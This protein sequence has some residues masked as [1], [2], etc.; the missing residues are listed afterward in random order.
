[1]PTGPLLAT[2][3]V[4]T[5]ATMALYSLPT[6][7][8]EVARD[9]RVNGTLAGGFVAIAYGVGIVSALLSPGLIRRH[10]GVRA[11]QVVL[12]AAAAMLVAAAFSS[13]IATLA[14][15][16]V[17]L[18][19][20]Y[21]AAAPA[22]THLLVPH[23]PR[24]IFNTVMSI[25]Q[26]G[27]PRGGVAAALTLPPLVPVFGWRGSLLL[28]LIP[29]L[30][31]ILLMELP[32]RHWDAD[33][34]PTVRP[35]GRTLL[36]P[37]LLLTDRRIRRLSV[38]CFIFSGLQ[39][40]FV[41]FTTVHLTT[42]TGLDLVRAGQMLAAYQIAGSVSR[43]IWGWVADRYLTPIQTLGFLGA[44]MAV[45]AAMT[46][47]YGR[48]WTPLEILSVSLV[49]GCTAGGYTGVAYAEYAS[50]GGARRTEATGLGTA[51]MFSGGLLIPPLFGASVVGWGGFDGAY[52]VM[53]I[54]A[55][56]SGVLMAWPATRNWGH[57]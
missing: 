29:V 20:G 12:L 14:C 22:S 57:L 35:F 26:I 50:L 39:L 11:T 17:V 4:Q 51:L 7:A 54:L 31:L 46:A 3:A 47:Q 36:Q 56:A 15:A 19:C 24:P 34:D 49:A 10:G 53:A 16:A 28:E 6:L 1:M 44:G 52:N 32:R 55:L 9:L 5:L 13:D 18:G 33:R 41:S 43:P 40:C 8:P 25:R 48:G 38:S 42:E 21:G 37:F 30:L 23:T 45:A 27:V 2:I